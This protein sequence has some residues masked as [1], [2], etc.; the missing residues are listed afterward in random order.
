MGQLEEHA[1]WSCGS[2]LQL[3][4]EADGIYEAEYPLPHSVA[5]MV[6]TVHGITNAIRLSVPIVSSTGKLVIPMDLCIKHGVSSPRYLLSALSMGDEQCTRALQSV[7]EEMVI[8]ARD[9]LRRAR[10]HRRD[11]LALDGTSSDSDNSSSDGDGNTVGKHTMAALLPALPS[12]TFL[13]RLESYQYDLTNR[14]L[15]NVSL[16]EHIQCATNILQASYQNRY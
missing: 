12:E 3:V 6:G 11:I 8:H 10:D 1:M 4:L 9:R 13:N 2:L 7:V 15:R 14:N 16:V 5:K